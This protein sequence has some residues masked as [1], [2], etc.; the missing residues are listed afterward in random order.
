MEIR[1]PRP[2]PYVG[3]RAFETG[4]Q[5]Y[6]REREAHDLLL[7]LISQRIV[8]LHSPSGAGKTSLVQAGLIP[9]LREEGFHV[10]PVAR[11]NLEPPPALSEKLG[12]GFNRYVYSVLLSLGEGIPP[13]KQV[14]LE[15]L[16]G[17]SLAQYLDQRPRPEPAPGE[18]DRPQVEVLIFDQFE[19]ILTID[20][21]DQEARA[22][23]FA[24]VGEALRSRHRWALFSMREDY[25][26]ALDPYLRSI[27]TRLA[28]RYRLDLLG[29]D[30]ALQAIRKPPQSQ[31]VD[32]DAEAAIKLTDDLRRVQIQQPDGSIT[33][34]PGSY[35]EPVQL[36]VVCYRLWSNLAP[37]DN[38][39]SADDVAHIGDVNESLRGYY[40]ERVASSAEQAGVSERKLREW[41]ERKL[42]TETGIRSQVLMGQGQSEGLD[43]GAIRLLENAHLVRAEK[44]R[45]VTWFEL[46]HDRL[47]RPVRQDNA[48]WFQAN[49]SLLQRQAEAWLREDRPEGMLLHDQALQDAEAWAEAHAS[50]L[51]DADRDFL[52]ESR[53][54]RL[55]AERE[56]QEQAQKLE[57]A[58]KLADAERTRAEEQSR[59]ARRLRRI[60]AV[61]LVALA[62][63]VVLGM[64][65]F[66][67]R[68]RSLSQ[69]AAAESAQQIADIRLG[70]F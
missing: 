42:I 28:S 55:Q 37:D 66:N 34:Q 48:D 50:E 19:E 47:I 49:L 30:A 35:V 56:R 13:D 11:V 61:T 6:G 57:L 24:Q 65:A 2:N 4:E 63:V 53:K 33:E 17:M 40:A 18:E 32:F 44:R 51:T 31:G 43:N 7:F 54:A 29:V 8:L 62:A 68:N 3:P 70:L 14:P 21:T 60:L 45:G 23:F 67:Y 20:P 12:T 39:I 64:L 1:N 36:Q 22:A 9:R 41:F 46:A 52:D 5:L 38:L 59:S 26:A 10:L 58:Q 25:I 27:P 15:Q 16:A 69:Q